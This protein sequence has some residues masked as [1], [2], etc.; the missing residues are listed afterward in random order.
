M[1][2]RSTSTSS[3]ISVTPGGAW[4]T[5]V[6]FWQEFRDQYSNGDYSDDDDYDDDD[7]DDDDDINWSLCLNKNA[8]GE[9]ILSW[10]LG[11]SGQLVALADTILV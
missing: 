10:T 4:V 11:R 6:I 7:D 2:S 3:S 5:Q 8:C 1:G 9:A